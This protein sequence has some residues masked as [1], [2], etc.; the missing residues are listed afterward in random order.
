MGAGGKNIVLG[1]FAS[2]NQKTL[3]PDKAA[4]AILKIPQTITKLGNNT[5]SL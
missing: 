3:I 2:A 1:F 5:M 4:S